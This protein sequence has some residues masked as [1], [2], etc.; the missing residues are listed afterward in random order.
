M[1]GP[2]RFLLSL[3][4]SLAL[5]PLGGCGG[6][7]KAAVRNDIDRQIRER[8]PAFAECYK[9]VLERDKTARGMVVL[10]FQ[11]AASSTQVG[12]VLV[13]SSSI[14]DPAFKQCV[15]LK[16]QGLRLIEAHGRPLDVSYPLSFE[17]L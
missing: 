17:P 7:L 1:R 3:A 13:V 15:A 16:A 9:A 10:G 8:Q 14:N 12:Q 6:N 11:V 2:I 5:L 4:L